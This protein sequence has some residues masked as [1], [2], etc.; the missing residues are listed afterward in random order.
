[1][2]NPSI[3]VYKGSSSQTGLAARGEF[4]EIEVFGNKETFDEIAELLRTK[5][6]LAV[7]P[8]WNSHEGEII[9]ARVLELLFDKKAR[10]Y[11]MW[12]KSIQFECLTRSTGTIRTLISVAVAETQCSKFIS[13]IGA[14]FIPVASTVEACE[15]FNTDTTIDALLC[16]PGQNKA[17]FE[18]V[19]PDA[20]N[21]LNFTTFG[22]LGGNLTEQW[23]EEEWGTL[24]TAR[25]PRQGIYFGVQ[26]PIR[27]LSSE[28][29]EALLDA[30]MGEA[31][32]F[33]EMPRVL[34]VTKRK[35]GLCGLLIE[36]QQDILTHD[37]LT[38]QGYSEE[39][40][41]VPNIGE[42]NSPYALKV[43][44]LIGRLCPE[45]TNAFIRHR[46][47][48]TCFYACPPL[49]IVTHGFE[50]EVVEP[51]VRQIVNKCFELYDR[52]AFTYTPA[53]GV[54]FEKYKPQYYERGKDFIE[55]QDI[56]LGDTDN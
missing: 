50:E 24:S 51:V 56:G 46:G 32:T 44:E 37:I 9:K 3:L 25:K 6:I 16:A 23:S 1:M 35:P 8:M 48:Q 36:A 13:E 12:P 5:A 26:M 21:P 15:K 40:T 19:K 38:E 4:P 30:L 53:Q 2:K 10:L 20:A 7:L 29:Q 14:V 55:F 52:S 22:L 41:I 27:T 28:D 18:M 33:D 42:T 54:F 34:F 39:I 17:K 47:K 11:R 43:K 31:R 45:Y 49:D